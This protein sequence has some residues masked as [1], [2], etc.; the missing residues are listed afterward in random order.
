[1][2]APRRTPY[3]QLKQ[4]GDRELPDVK[5]T[6]VRRQELRQ[7]ATHIAVEYDEHELMF[8]AGALE[9]EA[10]RKAGGR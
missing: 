4:L 7:R 2:I 10:Q 8:L 1:M 5:L 6:I 9:H 3:Y